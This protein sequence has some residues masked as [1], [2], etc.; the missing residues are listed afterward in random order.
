[1]LSE[2]PPPR[3]TA[4]VEAHPPHESIHS[5]REFFLQLITITAGVLIALSLEGLLEWNHYRILVREARETIS[6]E[7]ADNRKEIDI[8]LAGLDERTK[9]LETA[10][11]LANELLNAKKSDV[12]EITLGSNI[13]ELGA[14]SWQSAERTGALGH[15]DYAEVQ[16][17]SRI[18]ALQDLYT[19]HQR[20]SLERLSAALAMLSN[21]DP[22]QA[23]ARDLEAFRQQVMALRA[24]LFIDEQLGRRLAEI[25]RT[26]LE[27]YSRDCV[28]L[29][30]E[31][32]PGLALAIY[33]A[34]FAVAFGWRS[35][36][37]Y[38]RTGDHGFRGLSS[39]TGS[40][41]WAGGF[42][43]A[44]GAILTGAAAAAELMD[45]VEPI[46]AMDRAW[47]NRSGLVLACLG[48]VLTIVA[49]LQM[50]DSWRVGVDSRETTPLVTA[51]V[52]GIVRNPIFSAV[53]L[54][55]AGFFLMV[56]NLLSAAAFAFLIVGL[57]IQV[58]HVEEPHL[59]RVH[60]GTYLAYARRVGRFVPWVGHLS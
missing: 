24:D 7:I 60:P 46:A 27:H 45:L 40:V 12:H 34:F 55:T 18:Y 1:M 26:A 50:R 8:A 2:R 22:H 13:A 14:S 44:A 3:Y 15:M 19:D 9:N 37:Q 35:W 56:P 41:E 54:A 59:A 53:L 23:A 49:Q 43:V 21:G 36:L 32:M 48:F 16:S 51:G 5:F 38:R 10:L 25:Y 20:R 28:R 58:R 11:R 42:L 52:F 39:R 57:E 4:G 47:V 17:Y 6:R 30:P 33:V 29:A 31:T